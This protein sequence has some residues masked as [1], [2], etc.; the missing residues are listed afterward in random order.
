MEALAPATGV[1]VPRILGVEPAPLVLGAPF[2]VMSRV[3]GTVPQGRPSVHRAGWL[4][5]VAPRVRRRVYE[6]GIE[7]LV[8]VHA[9]DWRTTHAFLA[10]SLE[11]GV[12]L[13]PHLDRLARW[14]RWATAGRAYPITDA[15]IEHL[16]ERAG[17]VD[18][19]E[20]VLLWGDARISNMLCD[21]QGEV[22][23]ALDWEIATIGP[24]GVDVGWWLMMDTF[25]AEAQG[26]ERLE[27]CPDRATTLAWYESLSG[28]RIP[29]IEYFET[30]ATLQMAT[31]LIRQ[32]DIRVAD[33]RLAP[34][35]QMAH[36]NTFTQMLARRLGL[37][38]PELS[39][40]FVAHRRATA[41]PA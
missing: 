36:G 30:L 41:P 16:R 11:G 8:A 29:E 4:P 39:T 6:S 10:D 32:A 37:P 2:F 3:G 28:R 19:G 14:Y 24:A 21:D 33:G 31:T 20:A 12:S 23:A 40:E 38:V 26:I 18:E 7:T 25:H 35:N 5:T 9:A 34:G 1:P 13:G 17:R 27:G 15:A 22:T